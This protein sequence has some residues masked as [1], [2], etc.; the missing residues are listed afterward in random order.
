[1]ANAQWKQL[2]LRAMPGLAGGCLGGA[3]G[4]MV[5]YAAVNLEL[6]HV[7]GW[8]IMGLGIGVVEGI[9]EQ[10]KSKIRNGLIGGGVGGFLGGVFFSY[11]PT[12]LGTGS[13]M[14]GRAAGFVIL[15]ICIGAMIALAQ[16]VLKDAWLTVL[17]G[18]RT[19]RQLI[20]SQSVTSLGRAEHCP[21][22]FLGPMNR[23]LELQHVKIIRR[24]NGSYA[25][26]DN[27]TRLGTRL[28]NQPLQGQAVL[29]D[30]DVIKL[31]T[32]FVRFNERQRRKGEEAPAPQRAVGGKVTAPPPPPKVRK[33]PGAAAPGGP[34]QAGAGRPPAAGEAPAEE[35][36]YLVPDPTDERGAGSPGATPGPAAS[37][38][39][40]KPPSPPPG[41]PATPGGIAPP[42]PPRRPKSK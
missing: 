3:V 38:Q 12:L 39:P 32:N 25:V 29:K 26:E 1:M 17:D 31:G 42:P 22:P 18:Y 9:Y 28:N 11:V 34:P 14:S 8:L 16:V 15:G 6:P 40:G 33:R 37:P 24:P 5:G 10:S 41:R 7:I 35:G 23:D 19:G 21:L 4:A 36:F 30:G 2:L 13:E 20:L 27:Q